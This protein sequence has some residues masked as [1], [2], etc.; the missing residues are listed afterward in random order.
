MMKLALPAL[1]AAALSLSTTQAEAAVLIVDCAAGPFVTINGA[2]GAAAN[3]DTILVHNCAVPYNENVVVNGFDDLH[4]VAGGIDVTGAAV[5]GA[6]RTGN[7]GVPANPVTIDGS[8]LNGACVSISNSHDV[9]VVGFRMQRCNAGVEVFES[10]MTTIHG[11]RV[12][13]VRFAGYFGAGNRGTQL[14]SNVVR[15]ADYGV[16]L[17]GSSQFVMTD[18][19]LF[20]AR[21]DGAFLGGERLQASNNTIRFSGGNGIHSVFGAAHRL[22]R[23]TVT[24][25]L[26]TGGTANVFIAVGVGLVDIVANDTAGSIVDLSFSD[27]ADNL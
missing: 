2:V 8:G 15:G 14:T 19:M 9:S 13:S 12:Q 21:R 5:V 27:V 7:G 4:L 17:E 16:Y 22:E 23:N 25:N 11:N 1:C 6:Y 20:S 24:N 3:G 10:E 18:N 26:L